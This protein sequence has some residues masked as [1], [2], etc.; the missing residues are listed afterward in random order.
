[1]LPVCCAQDCRPRGQ[2]ARGWAHRR[3][4]ASPVKRFLGGEGPG[5]TWRAIEIGRGEGFERDADRPQAHHPV[6]GSAGNFPVT[7]ELL[8]D[9]ASM[10]RSRTCHC[11]TAY[12][13]GPHRPRRFACGEIRNCRQMRQ[14]GV[15]LRAQTHHRLARRLMCTG[16]SPR[17]PQPP[18]HA[19]DAVYLRWATSDSASSGAAEGGHPRWP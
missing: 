17:P 2:H 13:A 11:W 5:H 18:P 10:K 19:V 8:A 4:R 7:L 14:E 15:C 6:A 9:R 12:G 1:M 3:Y 16:R